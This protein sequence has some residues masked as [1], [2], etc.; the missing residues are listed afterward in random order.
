MFATNS[1]LD[2]VIWETIGPYTKGKQKEKRFNAQLVLEG[3]LLKQGMRGTLGPT[4][5]K[6][7]INAN[8]VQRNLHRAL[9]CFHIKDVSI[10]II[11]IFS[12]RFATNHLTVRVI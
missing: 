10:T 5:E 9:I 4:L 2:N 6:G 11:I 12:V 8:C 7:H 3:L 1:F